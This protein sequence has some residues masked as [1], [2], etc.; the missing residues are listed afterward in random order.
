MKVKL[1]LGINKTGELSDQHAPMT[2]SENVFRSVSCTLS[3]YQIFHDQTS[4]S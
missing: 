1:T 3:F 4:A 2:F